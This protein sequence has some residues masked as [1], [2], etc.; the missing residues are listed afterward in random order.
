MKRIRL[1]ASIFL[2]PFTISSISLASRLNQNMDKFAYLPVVIAPPVTPSPTPTLTPSPTPTR[3]PNS[4]PDVSVNTYG[5]IDID[6]LPYKNN[7][8]TDENADLRMSILGYSQTTAPLQLVDYN[9][10]T[11]PDAPKFNGVLK[12][13]PTFTRAYKRYNWNWNEQGPPPY[14]SRGDVNNDWPVSVLDFDT[15]LGEPVYIPNR[16]PQIGGGFNAMVLFAS[17]REI[18]FAYYR[19]DHVINGYVIHMMNFCVDPNLVALYRAQLLNGKRETKKLPG[20]KVDQVIG[21]ALEDAVTVAVRDR[22]AFL[23]PRSRKDW[24]Q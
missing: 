20:L 14:G 3:A 5:L 24:W 22:A 15:Q 2:I 11:D 9:G 13:V 16:N 4:C 1:L 17:E 10:A 21:T 8:I 6:G 12:R 19:Q 23:D 18:T 7:A